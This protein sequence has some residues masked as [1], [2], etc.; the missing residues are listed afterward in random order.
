MTVK[1][2]GDKVL[3]LLFFGTTCGVIL[4][5]LLLFG[6]LEIVDYYGKKRRHSKNK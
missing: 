6:L 1:S 2:V 3:F 5:E 4:N